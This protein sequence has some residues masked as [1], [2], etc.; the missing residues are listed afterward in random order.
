MRVVIVRAVRQLASVSIAT[1]LSRRHYVVDVLLVAAQRASI[2]IGLIT[3][4]NGTIE[5][6]PVAVRLHVTS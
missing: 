2:T 6:F 5:W 3:A 1:Q 4:L